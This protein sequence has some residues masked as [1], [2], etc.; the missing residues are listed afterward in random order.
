MPGSLS[1]WEGEGEGNDGGKRRLV[2]GN[3]RG[4]RMETGEE[5]EEAGK[6]E[7]GGKKKTWGRETRA[8]V[9]AGALG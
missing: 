2:E 3:K 5:E 7:R 1:S 9:S 6:R 8:S 4:G